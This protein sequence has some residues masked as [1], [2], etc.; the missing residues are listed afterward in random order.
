MDVFIEYLT[1]EQSVKLKFTHSQMITFFKAVWGFVIEKPVR[2]KTKN[3][4]AQYLI[5]KILLHKLALKIH[6]KIICRQTSIALK[7]E[8]AAAIFC[9]LKIQNIGDFEQITLSE[10]IGII[11]KKL[12]V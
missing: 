8:E 5:Y 4:T 7:P 9:A 1:P 3:E 6:K 10:I 2:L 11:D 12:L